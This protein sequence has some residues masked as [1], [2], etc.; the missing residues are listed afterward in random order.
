[1]SG[2]TS[3]F[4]SFVGQFS[5]DLTVTFVDAQ[6]E[7]A[8]NGVTHVVRIALGR[9]QVSDIEVELPVWRPSPRA[10]SWQLSFGIAALV[11]L[12]VFIVA[13]WLRRRT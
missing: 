4:S 1:M 11:A 7:L 5:R 12:G 13:A 8:W 3:E 9:E 2:L 10:R 6:H